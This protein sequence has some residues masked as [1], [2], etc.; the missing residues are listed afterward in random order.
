MKKILTLAILTGLFVGLTG[1]NSEE[2][3][4]Q[5]ERKAKREQMKQPVD[6]KSNNAPTKLPF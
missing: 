4:L 6:T 5:V 2:D 3:K 1:C